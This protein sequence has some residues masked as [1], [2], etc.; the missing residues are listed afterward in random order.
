MEHILNDETHRRWPELAEKPAILTV[1][2]DEDEPAVSL[3]LDVSRLRLHRNRDGVS[4]QV[5]MTAEEYKAFV[6][7]IVADAIE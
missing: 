2:H 7:S 6:I 3:W 4:V 5:W 1:N